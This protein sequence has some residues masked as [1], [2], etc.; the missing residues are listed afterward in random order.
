[1]NG[2]A[3]SF[4][5]RSYA[6]TSPHSPGLYPGISSLQLRRCSGFRLALGRRAIFVALPAL[7]LLWFLAATITLAPR[8]YPPVV[9]GVKR[10]QLSPSLPEPPAQGTVEVVVS[11]FKDDLSWL[12]ALAQL[13]NANVTV[14][15]KARAHL[16]YH[17][18]SASL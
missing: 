3:H 12:P 15:C 9:P 4:E 8:R 6:H 13:L 16:R 5:R 7:T 2:S 17:S 1:M 10:L 14:Y 11:R 18:V